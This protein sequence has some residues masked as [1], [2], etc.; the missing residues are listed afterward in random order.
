MLQLL[1]S[2]E[3]F[4]TSSVPERQDEQPCTSSSIRLLGC[5]PFIS[6]PHRVVF[7]RRRDRLWW[8]LHRGRTL[9]VVHT[10]GHDVNQ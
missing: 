9:S 3:M 7:F 2:V 10:L 1:H 6:E 5:C 4:R 8:T